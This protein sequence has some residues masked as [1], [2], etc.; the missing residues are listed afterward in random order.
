[1]KHAITKERLTMMK[2][3]FL[4]C[5]ILSLCTS[6]SE[7]ALLMSGS[8]VAISQNTY[9]KVYN[10]VDMLTIMETKKDIKKHLYDK[11]REHSKKE[12]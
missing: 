6:C 4:A 12:R 1:M 5:A 3:I 9:A 11:V 2:K 8:S 7:F 10:G